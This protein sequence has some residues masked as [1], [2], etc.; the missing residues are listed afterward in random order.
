MSMWVERQAAD[1][2]RDAAATRPA[3]LLTGARQTGKSSL[4]HHLYP[5]ANQISLD[6]PLLAA[7]ARENPSRFLDRQAE[8]VVVLD[9]IQY[10]PELFRELKIRIDADRDRCGHWILT[11]SQRFPLMEGISESLAGRIGIVRLNT[12]SAAELRATERCHDRLPDFVWRGGY[13]ELWAKPRLAWGAY[14]TDYIETYLERDLRAL[15]NVSSLSDFQ[16]CL[17]LC[18]LRAGQLVNYSEIARDTGVAL[19]TVKSWLRALEASGIVCLLPPYSA[20]I[21]KRLIKAPKLYFA[22]HGLLAF[23]LNIE[24][25]SGWSTHPC[26]GALWE[27]LV[28]L[29]YL[30]VHGLTPGRNLFFYRDQNGVEMDFVIER[31]GAIT[32]VEAKA[33]ELPDPGKTSF[34]KVQPLLARLAATVRCVVACQCQESEPVALKE[35][36][37]LNPLLHSPV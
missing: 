16:R 15:V 36:I 24:S 9:E 3:V 12:L 26:R 33:A 18:A 32:L 13:P 17:R 11:G 7:E 22:D 21:G 37:L 10:A 19:N 35:A 29:E 20:N 1:L 4:L 28:F 25:S 6:R 23:L 27:N 5:N 2:V 34:R 30:K 14:F 8:S 31:A